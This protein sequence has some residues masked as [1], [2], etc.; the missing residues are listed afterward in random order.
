MIESQALDA[1]HIVGTAKGGIVSKS[2]VV[3][4]LRA[5]GASGAPK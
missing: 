2:D 3:M 1:S 5:G 4:A